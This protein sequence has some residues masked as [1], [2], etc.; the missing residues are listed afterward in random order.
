MIDEITLVFMDIDVCPHCQSNDPGDKLFCRHCNHHLPGRVFGTSFTPPWGRFEAAMHSEDQ[1]TANLATD[2]FLDERT[3]EVKNSAKARNW[4]A[5]RKAEFAKH[6]PA[7][8]KDQ[9]TKKP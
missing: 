5:S 6:K 1:K 7:W 4:E 3:L 8:K 2:A 9:A